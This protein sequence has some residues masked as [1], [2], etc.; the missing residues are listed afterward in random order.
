MS[1][2]GPGI[3]PAFPTPQSPLGEP[4]GARGR[5]E[6]RIRRARWWAS[7]AGILAG[8]AAFGVGEAVYE[9]IPA[10]EKKVV[11]MGTAHTG[12]TTETMLVAEARNGAL[13][14]GVLGLCVGAF[15]GM[16]GGA[17]RRSASALLL[18]GLLG[19]ILGLALGAS[20][21]L[22]IVPFFLDALPRHTE[23]DLILSLIM[24]ASIWGLTGAAAGLAFAAG[25]GE[26][27]LIGRA[28]AAGFIGAVLGTLVFELVGAAA[29]PMDSTGRPIS[30]TWASRLL[31]RLMVPVATA[32]FVVLFVN[33]PASAPKEVGP[34]RDRK[35][36]EGT[37]SST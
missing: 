12:P 4:P 24:H 37:T 34:S 27:R 10:E 7:A 1:S 2:S 33:A 15:M 16:A 3:A 22:A 25:L 35:T 13:T 9:L 8:L 17:A 36:E 11:T 6:D 19:S 30:T 20:V 23:Y 31:A 18:A 5:S 26:S 32:A 28:T 29:F 21:S 14:F